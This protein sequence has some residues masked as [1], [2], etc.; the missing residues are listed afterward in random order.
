[1]PRVSSRSGPH[2]D[3]LVVCGDDALAARTIDQL[4]PVRRVRDR[5][6]SVPAAQSPAHIC[7]LLSVRKARVIALQRGGVTDID[8]L[9]SDEYRLAPGT[10]L[11]VLAIRAGLGRVL[12]RSR[13]A[14]AADGSSLASGPADESALL[15]SRIRPVRPSRPVK[16]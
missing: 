16:T 7:G 2:R 5:D 9:P 10:G 12:A 4:T 6:L 8:W 15:I 13:P 14:R 3:H 11:F 1:M